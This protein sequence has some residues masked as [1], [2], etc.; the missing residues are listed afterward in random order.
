MP[1]STPGPQADRGTT[2]GHRQHHVAVQL[3]MLPFQRLCGV[4]C[5]AVA[6]L[7]LR[8]SCALAAPL[9]FLWRAKSTTTK[10]TLMAAPLFFA[11]SFAWLR[12]WQRLRGVF[13]TFFAASLAAPL[14]RLCGVF[15][16]LLAAPL[17]RL[18]YACG[19]FL[20]RVCCAFGA[21]VAA[22]LPRLCGVFEAALLRSVKIRLERVLVISNYSVFVRFGPIVTLIKMI[23]GDSSLILVDT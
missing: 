12:F 22:P 20:R 10:A 2:A 23:M 6:T 8:L 7:W 21:S 15:I 19:A 5:Y 4:F 1:L 13:A 16:T 3:E 17:W 18:C 11:T 9:L 14:P